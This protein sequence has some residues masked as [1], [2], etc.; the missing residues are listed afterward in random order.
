M[1]AKISQILDATGIRPRQWRALL[2]CVSLYKC[3]YFVKTLK[4]KS[5]LSYEAPNWRQN[6]SN[7]YKI[8]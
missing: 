7:V 3:H 6:W 8:C 4:S 1:G 2:V 5:F